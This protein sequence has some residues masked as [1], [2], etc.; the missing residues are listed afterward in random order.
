M[1]N[2]LLVPILSFFRSIRSHFRKEFLKPWKEFRKWIQVF[3]NK[4]KNTSEEVPFLLVR[5]LLSPSSIVRGRH[6]KEN[7]QEAYLPLV[8]W[9]TATNKASK[10]K[11]S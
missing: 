8:L 9:R 2:W 3:A 1:K 6:G 4:A 5:F 7:E 10:N 11:I